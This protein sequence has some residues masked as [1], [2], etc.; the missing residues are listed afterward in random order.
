MGWHPLVMPQSPDPGGVHQKLTYQST[1]TSV[2]SRLCEVK[3]AC[4]CSDCVCARRD[5]RA[6]VRACVRASVC[7]G[8]SLAE[9]VLELVKGETALAGRVDEVK[10]RPEASLLLLRRLVLRPAC[11]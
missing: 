1:D 2:P 8:A 10:G 9:E 6:S 3:C 11:K 5:T 7:V 4:V